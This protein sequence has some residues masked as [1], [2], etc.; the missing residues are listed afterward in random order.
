MRGRIGR[1]LFG[2]A[3]DRRLRRV[4]AARRAAGQSAAEP[5]RP[6][7]RNAAAVSCLCGRAAAASIDDQLHGWR[8]RV[9]RI[10]GPGSH[11]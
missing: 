3:A 9:V 6:R 11:G 7:D 5:D 2:L 4:R 10:W 8:R 1:N